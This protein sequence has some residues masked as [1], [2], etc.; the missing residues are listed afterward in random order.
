MIESVAEQMKPATVGMLTLATQKAPK[1]VR[2][3][4]RRAKNQQPNPK[5]V[6]VKGGKCRGCH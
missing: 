4:L 6:P 3:K 5:R 1:P 2:V